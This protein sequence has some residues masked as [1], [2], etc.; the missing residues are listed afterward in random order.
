[1]TPSMNKIQNTPATPP[2]VTSGVI[3]ELSNFLPPLP[4]A[5]VTRAVRV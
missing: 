2:P 5:V 3:S 4:L 1:M